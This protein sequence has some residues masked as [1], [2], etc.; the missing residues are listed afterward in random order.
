MSNIIIILLGTSMLYVFAASR[1]EAYVKILAL[2]GT[3]LFLL[4]VVDIKEINWLNIAF[5]IVETLII[6]TIVIP[7][8]IGGFSFY[9]AAFRRK[10]Y[11]G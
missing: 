4:V 1:I 11:S 10:P 5:L 6:K 8:F 9:Y 3:L 2:Q 7:Y